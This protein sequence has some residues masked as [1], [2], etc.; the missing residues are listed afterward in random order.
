MGV[1]RRSLTIHNET[2]S[3]GQTAGGT[4]ANCD[5]SPDTSADGDRLAATQDSASGTA[6]SEFNVLYV[7]MVPV[8]FDSQLLRCRNRR[9]GNAPEFRSEEGPSVVSLEGVR[10]SGEI[11]EVGWIPGFNP[12]TRGREIG[13]QIEFRACP[14]RSHMIEVIQKRINS[15]TLGHQR[16]WRA[17]RGR[18]RKNHASPQHKPMPDRSRRTLDTGDL[19]SR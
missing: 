7:R 2:H 17:Q 11:A 12:Q 4:I 5:T 6:L 9:Y 8:Y 14:R 15:G 19:C 1:W 10:S 16:P 18:N 13:A 3:N